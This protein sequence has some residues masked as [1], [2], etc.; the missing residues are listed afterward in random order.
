MTWVI[1][2]RCM[3]RYQSRSASTMMRM[4]FKENPHLRRA[5]PRN[6]ADGTL[7]GPYYF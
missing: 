5:A 6:A 2:A 7:A 3:R 1:N 4:A